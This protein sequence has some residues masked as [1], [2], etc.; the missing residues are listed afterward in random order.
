MFKYVAN[1]HVSLSFKLKTFQKVSKKEVKKVLMSKNETIFVRLL[2]MWIGITSLHAEMTVGLLTSIENNGQQTFLYQNAPIKCE[3]FG[4]VTLEKMVQ[5]GA[6]P[7]ECRSAV[8]T[9]YTAHPHEKHF[10]REH[11]IFQQSY[12]YEI[13]PE[14]CVLYA[15][16]IETYSE[17]LLRNG[18]ALIDTKV[19]QKEWN[20]KLKRAEQGA[21]KENLG[22][23]GTLIRKWC[24]KEEK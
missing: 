13:L 1:T 22:L 7:Q 8:E 18:L 20:A 5:N 23:H 6:S 24:I 12:H 2:F 17:M 9:F 4:I 14:G 16:G 15:N 11:L 3:P 19:N 10:A 21:E